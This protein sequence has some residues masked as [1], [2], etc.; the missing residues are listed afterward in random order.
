MKHFLRPLL[1]ATVSLAAL[2]AQAAPEDGGTLIVGS[3]QV[4]RHF[5]GAIQS[6]TATAMA[7]TQIF[8]SPLRYDAEWNPQPYLAESWEVAEDGLSVTLHLTPGA[9]FHDGEP[10][11]SADVAFSIQTIK[12][13]HPFQ[14]MLAPVESVD[15][16]DELTA[17]I[18][19][20]QPHPALLLAM[21]PALMPIIP[22]HVY[23]EGDIQANPANLE[24]VGSGPFVFEEYRQGEFYRLSKNE[25]F[26][27][28]G[29]PYMDEVIVQIIGDPANL[30][31]ST[32]RG[33][34]D[35][36]PFA[37]SPRDIERLQG[38]DGLIVTDEGN[39][40]FGALN[41]LAF[42]TAKAPFDD[43]RVRQAIGFAIDKSFINDRL[44]AGL[45]SDSTGPIVNSSPLA[46]DEVETYAVDLDRANALLDEAGQM[47]DGD[48]IRF[49]MTVDYLPGSVEMGR[50]LAEY[51]RSQLRQ[52]GIEVEVRASPDFPTWAQR[53][54]S[55]DFDVTTDSVY[56]WGDP[57][58]GV[59]RT[60]L[61]SNI[62]EGV[63]W[64]N[65]QQYSNPRVDELLE[66]AAMEND[67][68]AR[69]ELYK[70]FQQIVVED[71]PI[72]YLN[73]APFFS[74]YKEGLADMPLSIWGAASPWDEI[75]WE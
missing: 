37:G 34:I 68:A 65:T 57:V 51:L 20:A 47:P 74:I 6:G 75:Y 15:T 58:I 54:S 73:V 7:S 3:T 24:P 10:I 70:E 55:Y 32:E 38:V 18:N 29:R 72:L 31:L 56:N 69:A 39:D 16:P 44:M 17:V 13:N 66:Q 71:A 1:A 45:V 22:E 11:T 52:I 12:E 53:I 2:S 64:S 43:A 21:S 28:E 63:I 59:N 27:I 4:P 49:T 42:N 46:T 41:W 9:T 60:Y 62:R 5:N 8:A 48:G 61:T 14:T 36:Y 19:L 33:D 26:F 25:N 35:Y 23:G 30:V 67:P 50:N 40:G